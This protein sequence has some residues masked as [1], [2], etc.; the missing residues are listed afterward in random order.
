MGLAAQGRVLTAGLAE[1]PSAKRRLR[2]AVRTVSEPPHG[3]VA[4]DT[5]VPQWLMNYPMALE[6]YRRL[7]TV[8][9]RSLP[10]QLRLPREFPPVYKDVI[11]TATLKKI[12]FLQMAFSKLERD[13]YV[14]SE[15]YVRL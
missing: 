3:A 4:A 5:V 14:T 12:F 13:G 9:L 6:S 1:S 2:S 11:I 7:R 8:C 10:L 15:S